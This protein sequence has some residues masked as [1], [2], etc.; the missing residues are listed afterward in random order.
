MRAF[1]EPGRSTAYGQQGMAATSH[2]LATLAA[3]DVLRA[4]GNAVDAAVAAVAVQC[5]VEPQMTGIGGD[6][7]VLLAPSSGGVV[8]LNGSG[9]APPALTDRP[10]A[11]SRGHRARAD[12]PAQRHRA[13]RDRRPGTLL[14]ERARHPR[15]GRA[16]AARRSA[17]PRTASSVTPRVAWDWQAHQRPDR[18][19]PRPAA[20]ST[21]PGGKAPEAGRVMR[22]PAPRPDP[23]PDRRG[24]CPQPSTRASSPRRMVATLNGRRRLHTVEDFAAAAAEFVEPIHTAYRDL[25]VYECPPNGQGVVALL[26]LNILERF[27]LA[28]ARPATATAAAAPPGRGDPPGLP[29][30]RRRSWPTPPHAEVPVARLLDKGYASALARA[31][32]PRACA[33]AACRRRCS[34]RIPTRSTSPSSTATSTPS[35]SSTRST[36]ASA[37]AWSARRP[38]S[39]STTAAAPSAS[40]PRHPNAVAPGKR[41]M[42]TIIPGMAFRGGE[43]WCSFGVMGG[44]YQ[45]VGHAHLLTSLVDD[46]L[47]PQAAL[48]CA[49]DHG[50]PGRARG[51]GRRAAPAA[52]AGSPGAAT[53]WST[54]PR[55]SA[56]V[57]PS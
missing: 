42:H 31:D 46:G 48:D 29:R 9:R 41:P 52:G 34:S 27:D 28:G 4:G 36:T 47:D 33:W 14:L 16:A 11:R 20:T 23:A 51:R 55:R 13:G 45:P 2:P 19:Q 54:P 35:R 25:R 7:F 56:A 6:C 24:G 39:C 21:C 40:T 53:A 30:P 5:V 49:A 10:A 15:P 57:R 12:E 50:L 17:A 22:L 1:D 8:A 43:L 32:R 26:M 44:D 3:L 38:A 37:P 18:P